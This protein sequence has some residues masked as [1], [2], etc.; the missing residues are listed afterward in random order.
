MRAC[1]CRG[2]CVAFACNRCLRPRWPS[3]I[4]SWAPA[5]GMCWFT[6]STTSTGC[7]AAS[8]PGAVARQSGRPHY[9][10]RLCPSGTTSLHSSQCGRGR[11]GGRHRWRRVSAAGD[12]W[13]V[14]DR[15]C[16]VHRC[17]RRCVAA[18]SGS[19]AGLK[20]LRAQLRLLKRVFDIDLEHCPNCGGE[21]KIIAAIL[22]KPVIE[23]I[24]IGNKSDARSVRSRWR[25]SRTSVLTRLLLMLLRST[26][27]SR[28]QHTVKARASPA[29]PSAEQRPPHTATRCESHLARRG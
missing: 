26:G 10:C 13:A 8:V 18:A 17:A 16:A 19:L 12:Q 1:C 29:C 21:L 24:P 2:T 6:W 11:S 27:C 4:G 3:C 5:R 15:D 7:C 9:R 23:K 28:P 22:E 25:A 20:Y 14:A